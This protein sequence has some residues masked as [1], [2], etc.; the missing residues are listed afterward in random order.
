MAVDGGD[1]GGPANRFAV[2]GSSVSLL[3]V[4]PVALEMGGLQA[5][6]RRA[7]PCLSAN[8]Y[9]DSFPP[10]RRRLGSRART[11]SA[12][13]TAPR[14][15]R[16]RRAMPSRCESPF[17]SYATGQSRLG[18]HAM[19]TARRRVGE[20][21]LA[22]VAAVTGASGLPSGQICWGQICGAWCTCGQRNDLVLTG[23]KVVIRRALGYAQRL[24][25]TAA[26]Q[27]LQGTQIHKGQL[28]SN[29]VGRSSMNGMVIGTYKF[30]ADYHRLI[31]NDTLL[32]IFCM[33]R[34]MFIKSLFY[35]QLSHEVN[36]S[37]YYIDEI[38][39]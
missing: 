18:R 37:L 1:R 30:K 23:V 4:R 32:I 6:C 22:G 38:L 20:C 35:F 26:G 10:R 33:E 17:A 25:R 27:G 5:C 2:R 7:P 13:P 28:S 24:E 9:S 16:S 3:A 39:I 12:E 31:I 11:G 36:I 21:C 29:V 8:G 14:R 19:A 15:R 34:K